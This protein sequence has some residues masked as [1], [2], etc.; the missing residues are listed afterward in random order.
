MTIKWDRDLHAPTLV[1]N[2]ITNGNRTNKIFSGSDLVDSVGSILF[3]AMKSTGHPWVT[4]I[5]T[6]S[7]LVGRASVFLLARQS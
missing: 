4:R 5:A 2:P 3:E 1:A 7:S 6:R